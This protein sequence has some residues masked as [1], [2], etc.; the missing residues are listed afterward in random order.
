MSEHQN[1][2]EEQK[3]VCDE[4]NENRTNMKEHEFAKVQL[5]VIKHLSFAALSFYD[6]SKSKSTAWITNQIKSSD[7]F[8]HFFIDILTLYQI[9]FR[10]KWN[11]LAEKSIQRFLFVERRWC[12]SDTLTKRAIAHQTLHQFHSVLVFALLLYE[13]RLTISIKDQLLSIFWN[14]PNRPWLYSNIIRFAIVSY[15]VE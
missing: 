1:E 14:W 5:T 15:I 11:F 10:F 8:L 2:L 4:M 3:Q 12:Y 7:F 9:I 6:K 13:N